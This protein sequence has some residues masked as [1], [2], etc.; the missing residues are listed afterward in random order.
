MRLFFG[1]AMLRRSV[2]LAAIWLSI[3]AGSVPRA[4]AEWPSGWTRLTRDGHYKQRP[5]WSPDG[6][7]VLFTRHV[8]DTIQL[9]RCRADGLEEQRLFEGPHPRMDA[10]Y[11][12]DGKRL[13]LTWDNVTTGQGDMDVYVADADG[14][15][16]Q[17]LFV[18]QGKL[19]HEEWPSWSPEGEWI[20]C[21]STRDDNAELY[22]VKVDGS[23]VQRLTSDPALDVHPA[24]SPDGKQ[25]AFATNRW[26]DLEIAVY[27]LETSRITRLTESRGLDDYPAWSPDGRKIAFTSNR[28][29]NL[30]IYVMDADG[31]RP[32]NV[33]RHPG[34]DCFPCWSPAGDLTFIASR[35]GGWDIYLLRR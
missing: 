29:G 22:R 7:F 21:S 35:D 14:E 8:Q 24:Y 27:S 18:S 19:S 10:V 3:A 6:K 16:P 23:V 25:I 11:S 33:T 28:D 12:P 26:G 34:S 4:D 13:A 5:A 20:V 32:R 31:S 1:L 15:N 2:L 17:P 9:I 30:E